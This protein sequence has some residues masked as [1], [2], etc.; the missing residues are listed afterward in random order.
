M[1]KGRRIGSVPKRKQADVSA[2]IKMNY[3]ILTI[4]SENAAL[5]LPLLPTA[6]SESN[7]VGQVP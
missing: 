1:T 5:L 3:F 4:A 7:E 6:A 2:T